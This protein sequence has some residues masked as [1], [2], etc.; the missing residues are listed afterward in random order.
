LIVESTF[1]LPQKE[2]TVSGVSLVPTAYRALVVSPGLVAVELRG[3]APYTVITGATNTPNGGCVIRLSLAF[4]K[5][6]FHTAP[7]AAVYEPLLQHSRRGLEEDSV[8]WEH[9]SPPAKPHW[10]PGDNPSL[11]FLKFCKNYYDECSP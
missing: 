8:I 11:E 10:M 9:L 1:Y 3:V 4:P 2:I 5:A 6:V 7:P